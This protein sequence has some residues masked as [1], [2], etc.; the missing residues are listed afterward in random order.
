MH[1]NVH[2]IAQQQF[3]FFCLLNNLLDYTSVLTQP[4]VCVRVSVCVSDCVSGGQLIGSL[5]SRQHE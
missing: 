5:L 3:L 4:P 1:I 2:L